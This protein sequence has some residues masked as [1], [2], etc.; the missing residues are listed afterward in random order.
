MT[1]HERHRHHD[2]ADVRVLVVDDDAAQRVLVRRVL[3]TVGITRVQFEWDPDRVVEAVEAFDPDLVTL[4][5]HLAGG[6]VFDALDR[7]TERDP[8][9]S[10]RRV[11]VVT[12]DTDPVLVERAHAVGAHRVVHKPF[13][14]ADFLDAVT[15]LV[16]DGRRAHARAVEAGDAAMGG[17]T[18][19]SSPPEPDGSSL[20]D[21]VRALADARTV[22]DVA[23]LV[24]SV[25]R[26]LTGADGATF[27]L[28]E[29]DECHYV[30]ED[31]ISPLWKGQR[32]PVSACISG[33][34]MQHREV[35]VIED[36]YL[37][38]RIPHDVYRPTFVKS[39]VMVPVRT[40]D[41]I[42]AIGTYWSVTRQPTADELRLLQ[43]LA[44][45][46]AIALQNALLY[47]QLDTVHARTADLTDANDQLRDFVYAVAHDIR[48]PLSTIHGLAELLLRGQEQWSAETVEAIDLIRTSARNL[49]DFV[50]DLLDFAIADGRS[51]ES[52]ALS[53]QDLVEEVTD[54]LVDPI[55][56]R[57]ATVTLVA[58]SEIVGD[59]VML[60]QVLQNLVANALAYVPADR[61]P[62]V[63]IE[64][65]R[66]A[67]GWNLVVS[68]NGDGVPEHERQ[69]IFDAFRRG[70]G[71]LDRAGTGLGLALCQRVARRHGGDIIVREAT[72][73][74]AE[75]VMSLVRETPGE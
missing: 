21:V 56:A 65:S 73:G 62:V 44:D 57:R 26:Q 4:D 72:T 15:A 42:A 41:P 18:V 25:A 23:A 6:D 67:A 39:L 45:T 29:G 58:D 3:E 19:G 14:I 32:F 54:R 10:R 53:L 24:R 36:I 9:W 51:I 33:W 61:D 59:R 55:T 37:D 31:A 17:S 8:Q 70:S 40:E 48:S 12:G 52:E 16:D 71:G 60:V 49:S 50:A 1:G 2:L 74:G 27:V 34:A 43:A 22:D 63:R 69:L 20:T 7:I 11:L 46:T 68:D 5:V 64:V 30:D 35:A 13:A 47:R 75:F 66:T 38:D 28:R